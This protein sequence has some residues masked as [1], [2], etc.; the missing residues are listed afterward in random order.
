MRFRNSGGKQYARAEVHLAYRVPGSD[1]TK[2]TFAWADDAGDHTAAHRFTGKPGDPPWT[3]PTGKN[4]R[5][6][7]VEMAVVE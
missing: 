5:T 2:T 4:V 6:K 3:V 1:A 7:W